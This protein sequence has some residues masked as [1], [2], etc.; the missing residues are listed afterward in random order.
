MDKLVNKLTGST[1]SLTNQRSSRP[2]G[3]LRKQLND[4]LT[5]RLQ[6]KDNIRTNK[7]I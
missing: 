4:Q 5:D 7:A 3:Q 2:E 1:Y 6:G